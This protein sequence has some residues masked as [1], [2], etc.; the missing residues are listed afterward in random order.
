[1]KMKQIFFIVIISTIVFFI[2]N[3]NQPKPVLD[4]ISPEIVDVIAKLGAS[5]DVNSVAFSPDGKT[6][7]SGSSDNS[8]KWWNL[9]TQ[10]VV[11]TLKGHDYPIESVVFAP[12]GKT[13]LSASKDNTIKYWN[14]STGQVLKT[15]KGHS[16]W[17]Q[18]VAFSPNGKFALSG[19]DDNTVKLW[20]LSNGRVIK[21]LNEHSQHVLA[22]AFS[23][24]G[25][26]VLSASKDR[27]IK[28]WDLS[29]GKV[30]KTLSGHSASVEAITLS[31]D[32]KK[33]LS[34]S[35]DKTI[36][37]W[38]LSTGRVVK[39]LV[40][41]SDSVES[42][43]FSPDGKI[44]LSGS[45]DKTIKLWDLSTGQVIKTLEKHSATIKSVTFS[46]NG[47][48]I[49]SASLDN[50]IRLWN[51]QSGEEI[52]QMVGFKDGE[53]VAIAS[54][55]YYV[56][57]ANSQQYIDIKRKSNT[58]IG[59][60]KK[61]DINQYKNFFHRPDIIKRTWLMVDND[62]REPALVQKRLA[63]LIGNAAYTGY[64]PLKNPVNDANDLANVLRRLN[65]EVM[66]YNNLTFSEMGDAMIEFGKKL[67]QNPG[68]GL[69]YFSGHGVQY[70]GKNYLIPVDAT[71]VLTTPK[72][73][74]FKTVAASYIQ[75]TME[76][77]GN[78]INLLILDAC[79]NKPPFI[80]S[81]FKDIAEPPGIGYLQST[82]G[83]LIAYAASPGGIAMDGEGR[84][85]PYIKSLIKWIEQPNLSLTQILMEVR[86]EV[87]I[88][89]NKRQSPGYYNEL[90]D[91]FY[92]AH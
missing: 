17:V 44:A 2:Y 81:L 33:V 35:R 38:D 31:P 19:S 72:Q 27:S 51:K 59:V 77:A 45:A 87:R 8:L 78:S 88:N 67:S 25:E 5:N 14:L 90:N 91:D 11:K 46:P 84:N 30:I 47:K 69:F 80:K 48:L 55:A 36:K 65:F 68:V 39:T 71:K 50:T 24:N 85:S 52:I 21:T 43:A 73:L 58:K 54:Q 1:M 57:S 41:H 28:L 6:I 53:G 61:I 83:S 76:N 63:L 16:D 64:I 10:N 18:A 13:A 9:S 79:R 92:F 56:A 49:L 3:F 42:V 34:A 62:S 26:T 74:A 12:D 20:E 22:V 66:I 23:L 32:G 70:Q 15:L 60:K 82:S 29:T 89:T 75:T 7:L 37:L 40:G 4:P 86:K